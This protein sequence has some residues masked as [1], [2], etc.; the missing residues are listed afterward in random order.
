MKKDKKRVIV[1]GTGESARYFLQKY[2]FEFNIVAVVD[3]DPKIQSLGG[4]PVLPQSQLRDREFDAI[5]VASWAILEIV[6]RLEAMGICEDDIL[7]FQ[8][9]RNQ[10]VDKQVFSNMTLHPEYNTKD[11]L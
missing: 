3:K 9:N 10:V 4:F 8:H 7:W 5:L 1:Y 6:K 11:I 2:Q